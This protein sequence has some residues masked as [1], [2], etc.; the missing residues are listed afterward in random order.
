M[1]AQYKLII[2]LAPFVLSGGFAS[3]FTYNSYMSDLEKRNEVQEKQQLNDGL[4]AKLKGRQK[5]ELERH[6]LESDIDTLRHSVPKSPELDL[7]LLDLDKMC[8]DSGVEMV[9]VES[10]D[11]ELMRKLDASEEEE[12]QML[13]QVGGQFSIGSKSM[14]PKTAP[15]AKPKDKD[16]DKTQDDTAL[17]QLVKHVYV[18]GQYPGIVALMK[19]LENYERVTG[20]KQLCIGLPLE[21]NEFMKNPA[22]DRAKKLTLH[23]PVASF[24]MT[25]YYLP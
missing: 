15:P 18:T 8:K 22:S 6:A 21:G 14:Q 11:Q 3:A 4:V 24:L 1:K 20:V 17:K 7:F 10:P 25:L 16:K 2:A 13:E 5:A 12:R 9:A 23:Q 19:R